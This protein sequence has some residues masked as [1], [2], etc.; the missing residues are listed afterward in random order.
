MSRRMGDGCR[1]PPMY[2]IVDNWPTPSLIICRNQFHHWGVVGDGVTCK[3]IIHRY[4][5]QQSN[6]ILPYVNI[7]LQWSFQNA[8]ISWNEHIIETRQLQFIRNLPHSIFQQITPNLQYYCRLLPSSLYAINSLIFILCRRNRVHVIEADGGRKE[9]VDFA[10]LSLVSLR[11]HWLRIQQ[12][13]QSPHR[14]LPQI[15]SKCYAPPVY[16]FSAIHHQALQIL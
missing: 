2:Y 12:K 6:G 3:D 5:K 4:E 13:G 14:T 9:V 1:G 8:L 11:G 7:N 16:L 15:C 10:S